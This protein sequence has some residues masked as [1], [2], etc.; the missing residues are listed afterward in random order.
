[1]SRRRAAGHASASAMRSDLAAKRM[2]G[3]LWPVL[4]DVWALAPHTNLNGIATLVALCTDTGDV[5]DLCARL[6]RPDPRTRE[7]PRQWMAKSV[8]ACRPAGTL[9]TDAELLDWVGADRAR[10]LWAIVC[11]VWGLDRPTLIVAY[12]ELLNIDARPAPL[13][14]PHVIELA[15]AQPARIPGHLERVAA[16]DVVTA[17]YA[18]SL[19]MADDGGVEV[20]LPAALGATAASL[21]ADP[22]EGVAAL[23]LLIRA[24]THPDV[25]PDTLETM[26]RPASAAA[27]LAAILARLWRESLHEEPPA[28]T[29]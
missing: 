22:L 27:R 20:T 16:L 17:S 21:A 29:P 4:A 26:C 23:A 1:M 14:A 6:G 3:P 10:R 24:Y 7:S 13:T 2:Y 18:R 11:L 25:T 15:G 9:V 5:D 28:L 19:G 12:E 8:P